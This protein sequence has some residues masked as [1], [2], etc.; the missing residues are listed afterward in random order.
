MSFDYFLKHSNVSFSRSVFSSIFRQLSEIQ[1]NSGLLEFSDLT[2]AIVQFAPIN[3]QLDLYLYTNI[4]LES[5]LFIIVKDSQAKGKYFQ[6]PLELLFDECS[7]FQLIIKTIET[8]M[9][10]ETTPALEAFKI[11][12]YQYLQDQL[13]SPISSN[14]SIS[15]GPSSMF[16]TSPGSFSSSIMNPP[17][18]PPNERKLE[19]KNMIHQDLKKY[20][21][22]NTL[23]NKLRQYNMEIVQPQSSHDK[24]ILCIYLSLSLFG[25]LTHIQLMTITLSLKDHHIINQNDRISKT[26][27]RGLISLI[28]AMGIIIVYRNEK[29]QALI[30]LMENI[31]DFDDI[32]RRHDTY[33][34]K[35]NQENGI[36]VPMELLRDLLWDL[37][38]E[39]RQARL[40]QIEETSQMMKMMFNSLP[41]ELKVIPPLKDEENES[42]EK[43]EI[44][45]L[46]GSKNNPMFSAR[47]N[48]MFL[49]GLEDQE[50]QLVGSSSKT[51]PESIYQASPVINMNMLNSLSSLSLS[52]TS[53]YMNSNMKISFTTNVV[54]DEYV[55]RTNR[56]IDPEYNNIYASNMYQRESSRYHPQSQTSRDQEYLNMNRMNNNNTK[57]NTSSK[58][59]QNPRNNIKQTRT[60]LQQSAM[61]SDNTDLD[62]SNHSNRMY[63]GFGY[64]N[65][66]NSFPSRNISG[67]SESYHNAF[68]SNNS[69]GYSDFN[70]NILERQPH[71]HFGGN[72][73]TYDTQASSFHSR[74]I[75]PQ[76][77]YT[78]NIN[79]TTN[80]NNTQQSRD[81]KFNSFF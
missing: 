81:S 38:P 60:Y 22:L 69:F 1:Q 45:I 28:K 42:N 34:I 79:N 37:S 15:S 61:N 80:T 21:S 53:N 78:N 29:N 58:Y 33:L 31:Q 6:M 52:P 43:E 9:Q 50:A 20:N 62:D 10:G 68:E 70:H 26:K 67:S 57:S 49:K 24:C 23:V 71:S 32:R 51:T 77:R 17:F 2:S 12:V 44:N 74:N 55:K 76:T 65:K 27:L 25:P 73:R 35:F 5:Q 54:S 11:E 36:N 30:R 13:I 56:D 75:G 64:N 72:Q 14:H 40:N 66:N 48:F 7:F 8:I 4:I 19:Q 46:E 39:S 47:E 41:N 3:S 59:Y 63:Q 16:P 18:P